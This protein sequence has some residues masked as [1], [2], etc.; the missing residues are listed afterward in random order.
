VIHVVMV[1]DIPAPSGAVTFLFTDVEGSTRLWAEDPDAMSASLRVHDQ[2]MRSSIEARGGYVFTTAG[3]AFCAAFARASDGL[4]A[5]ERTQAALGEASWPGPA[6]RVRM[7]LHLG[8]AEERGG[9]YF[10]SVVNLTARLGAVAHGGQ[11]VDR[12]VPVLTTSRERLDVEGELMIQVPP[13]STATTDSAAVPLFVQR[14][15]AVNPEFGIDEATAASMVELCGRLDGVPLA[16]ERRHGVR[17]GRRLGTSGESGVT[18]SRERSRCC[19]RMTNRRCDS[20]TGRS[21]RS[22]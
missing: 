10:G 12:C 17:Y 19:S 15:T 9:D 16:I 13:L 18:C 8:E 7:G 6:L 22:M 5:A 1:D 3:D 2:I 4:A 21:R 11:T 14:A 20:S